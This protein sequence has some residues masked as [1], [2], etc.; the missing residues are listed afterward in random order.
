VP[1]NLDELLK[2]EWLEADGLG[3]YA[4]GTAA[5]I[6]TRRYHGLLL[7][8]TKPPAG[9][10]MLVSGLDAWIETPA[11][12]VYLSSHHYHPDTLHPDGAHRL[13]AF[14]AEPWPTWTYELPTGGQV[15]FELFV[16]HE[17]A[18]VALRWRYQGKGV[19]HLRLCVRPFLSGR[20]P[21]ALH[22]ENPSYSFGTMVV[23]GELQW[24]NYPAI[25]SVV[26]IT[27]A[28]YQHDPLWYRKF[29]YDEEARRGLDA[30]E[31]LASP[32][33]MSWDLA[34]RE[35][36]L[37][38]AARGMSD[39][40]LDDSAGPA[41]LYDALR[42]SETARRMSLGTG[43]DRAADLYLVRRGAGRTIIAG[44][45]WFS[46]WGRDTF[47]ALRGLTLARGRL[48]EAAEILKSWSGLVS[49]GMV[50]NRFT[51][52]DDTPEYNAVDASLWFVIAVAE[53]LDAADGAHATVDPVLRLAF[54][55]A[56]EGVLDGYVRGT[57]FRIRLDDD[58]LIAAGEPGSPLTWMD[59]KIGDRGVT[60]RVG[61][62]IEVQCLWLNALAFARRTAPR[63]E[64]LFVK[65]LASCRARYFDPALGYAVDVLDVNHTPGK[66]DA[67]L[68]PNQIYAVG[69]LPL[70]LFDGDVA[71]RV[72]D[73]VEAR[74]LTPLGLRSLAPGSTEYAGRYQGDSKSRD[75]AYHQGTVWPFLL[76]P[77][78]EAWVR[79]RGGG[80]RTIAEARSRF[81]PAMRAH[82]KQAGL[83]HVSEIAD[84]EL[85][86]TPRGCPFQA[87]SVGEW[88]RI[89]ALLGE[90]LVPTR[91][92]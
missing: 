44:Y 71:R 34:V 15:I 76:G 72:V 69:G 6:R 5:G 49:E 92:K 48:D 70:M 83:G 18:A 66:V 62:P 7:V 36:R 63:F 23:D 42:A 65:G 56:V 12:R 59:A 11:G 85:P 37:V 57:R 78:I 13:V 31:D 22:H 58:G 41:A 45:P 86:H 51:D 47:M 80:P 2:R 29:Q 64:A 38:L 75:E 3:G 43:L 77:F 30:L 84:A 53:Y 1:L 10:I 25:P 24:Q 90:P 79:V 26:A 32:G 91:T 39:D 81:L 73:T 40:V 68:R 27:D 74:L 82:L 55:R 21:H 54:Q 60:P 52:A 35:A 20:E 50:P 46:D 9:R 33:T 16:P 8:A 88:L 14:T 17:R 61:K 28:T 4:L 89:Q 67:S 19:A 87:W